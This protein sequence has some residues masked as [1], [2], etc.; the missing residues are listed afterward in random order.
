MLNTLCRKMLDLFE[1]CYNGRQLWD[2]FLIVVIGVVIWKALQNKKNME[3]TNY[4]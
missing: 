4:G 3:V 2:T 1:I